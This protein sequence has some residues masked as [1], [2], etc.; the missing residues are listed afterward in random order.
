MSLY[1][2]HSKLPTLGQRSNSR[3]DLASASFRNDLPVFVGGNGYQG[4]HQGDGYTY[5]YSRT[6]VHGGG[7]GSGGQKMQM[8]MGTMGGGVGGGG[9]GTR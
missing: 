1:G 9:G 7:G 8:S 2:S 5:S 3:P 6:S 4:E